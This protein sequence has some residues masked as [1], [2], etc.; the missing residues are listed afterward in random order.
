MAHFHYFDSPKMLTEF[1]FG[2]FL[3]QVIEAWLVN[4]QELILLEE[5]KSQKFNTN[6]RQT[7]EL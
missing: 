2:T 7:T 4:L 6:P 1:E 3:R 5:T